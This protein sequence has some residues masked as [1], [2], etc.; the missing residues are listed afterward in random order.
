MP[1]PHS[2]VRYVEPN[3]DLEN[4]SNYS[5]YVTTDGK[6]YDKIINPED[7]CIGLS[8]TTELCN[9]GQSSTA[10]NQVVMM[11]W[12]NT[13]ENS[14]VN[15]MSGTLMP[16]VKNDSIHNN[17]NI[18]YLTT[19][20]ADM[21]VSDL[22]HYG[23]TEMIG[24][25]SVNIDFENATLPVI[26]VQ[27]TDVR[28]MSLFTPKEF[29]KNKETIN[30]KN[31]SQ[32][33]FQCFFK[34]PYPKFNITVKGFYGRPVTYE[35]TCDKFDT[36][37][38]AETGNFDVTVRFIGY[39]YSF[40]SDITTEMLLLAPYTDYLG[41]KYWEEQKQ[42]GHFTVTDV[43]G[44]KTEMPTLIETWAKIKDTLT[45]EDGGTVDTTLTREDD[46]HDEEIR[47]L[48]ELKNRYTAWYEQLE[49]EVISKY[50]KDNCF[51]R[52]LNSGEYDRIIVLIGSD[53]SSDNLST[54][55]AKFSNEMT[56]VN[57][58]LYVAIKEYNTAYGGIEPLKQI[59]KDYSSFL[60]VPL[61]NVVTKNDKDRFV[62]NGYHNDS[63][64][65]KGIADEMV[66]NR[67]GIEGEENIRLGDRHQITLRT[68]YNDGKNQKT[69]CYHINLEYTN[70]QRR[71]DR[72]T[73]DANKSYNEKKKAKDIHNRNVYLIGKLGFKPTVENFTKI[74]MAHLETLM[75]MIYTVSNE[76][77]NDS[78]RKANALGLSVGKEG[79]LSDVQ[80]EDDNLII[81]PFP[82]VTEMV[83]EDDGTQKQ[84]DTWV[85]KFDKDQLKEVDLVET[86]FNAAEYVRQ[87]VNTVNEKVAQRKQD[88]EDSKKGIERGSV[89]YPLTSFD[90]FLDS[91]VYGNDVIET[92]EKFAGSISV[93]MFDILSLNFFTNE[94]AKDNKW[95]NYA[96]KLGRTEAHNFYNSVDTTSNNNI[97]NWIKLDTGIFN[98]DY[99]L[100]TV[101]S[102][103]KE[104][105]FPWSFLESDKTAPTALMSA[106]NWLTRY[107]I[108]YKSGNSNSTSYMYQMQ[109]ISFDTMKENYNLFKT[110]E[111][112]SNHD[113]V[114]SR[115]VKMPSSMNFQALTED[116]NGHYNIIIC[117][118]Y[119]KVKNMMDVAVAE[120]VSAYSEVS[121][122]IF[123]SCSLENALEGYY[124][125]IFKN[126]GVSSFCRK[127]EEFKTK[128]KTIDVRTAI[129]SDFPLYDENSKQIKDSNNKTL[130]FTSKKEDL[131]EYFN[132]EING[133]HINSCF[134]SE[135]FN[136]DKDG[137]M[138]V[139][140]SVFNNSTLN[141]FDFLMGIDCINYETL[142]R[143][144]NKKTK[145]DKTFIYL[146]RFVVLQLGAILNQT[147]K[148][149][150]D[151]VVFENINIQEGLK[152][153]AVKYLNNISIY[154]RMVLV[155][156]YQDWEN[157]EFTTI[158]TNL[159][160][161]NGKKENF[162]TILYRM[163]GEERVNTRILLNP[164][165]PF[166]ES[167]TNQMMLP[168]LLVNGNVNHFVADN[169]GALPASLYRTENGVYKKYLDGFI[170]EL[171]QLLGVDYVVD[172]SGNMVRRS[173]EAKNTSDEMRMELYR[174]IKNIYDKWIPSSN[175]ED[176]N[177]ENF[178]RQDGSEY[179]F[180]FIDSYYNK[181][182][183]KLLLNPQR[184]LDRLEVLMAYTD[185]KSNMLSFLGYIYRDNHCMF[186][187]IQNFIDLSDR[188]AMDDMFKPLSYSTAFNPK[189]IR[190]GQDFV[191]C[192]T[193]QP[194]KY[195]DI[196]GNDYADDSFMLNDENNSPMS[197]RTR[198]A[199]GNFYPMPAFGV[200]YGKQYQSF[201]K[202]VQVSSKGATQ[203]EQGIK[204]KFSIL[205]E[206]TNKNKNGAQGQD[207]FDIYAGQ[208]FT[209]TVEMMGCAW[210]QPMMYFVLLNVPMFRGSYQI[211]KVSHSITP[212]NM[213]TKFIGCRM[214]NV[215]NKLV[216]DVF[217]D[218]EG[219]ETESI[220]SDSVTFNNAMA[221]NDNDCPY[222]VFP[223][224][225]GGGTLSGDEKQKA[226]VLMNKVAK[227][228]YDID[229]LATA[230]QKYK[231][232]AAGI[233]GNMRVETSTFDHTAVNGN[234]NNHISGGLC[235][236]RDGYGEL[237]CL[238][239]NDWQH[240][241][242]AQDDG[243]VKRIA[244][245]LGVNGVKNR[246]QEKGV[247]Y[248]IEFLSKTL[249]K[250]ENKD[251]KKNY[252]TYEGTMYSK[253]ALL[254]CSTPENAALSFELSYEKSDKSHNNDRK[255][256]ARQ[257]YDAYDN[258]QTVTDQNELTKMNEEIYEAFFS[259]VNQTAQNTESMKFEL[260][261]SYYPSK[262]AKD[263]TM[264]IGAA[265]SDN[266]PK[267]A[268]LF[269]CILNTQE[270]FRYVKTLYW[271][272]END[273]KSI[274]RVDVKLSAKDVATNQQRVWLYEKGTRGS[275]NPYGTVMHNK[276]TVNDLSDDAKKSFAKKYK[277]IGNDKF[278]VLVQVISD[279]QNLTA[280]TISDC[281]SVDGGSSVGNL[282]GF[283]GT[284]NNPLMKKVLARVNEICLAHKYNNTS[285]WY[286][287]R[288]ANG[289]NPP[290]PT[291]QCT[292][293]PSTWY[294][295]AGNQYD[296]HFYPGPKDATYR[297]TTLKNYGFKLV[298]HGTVKDA[299]ALS[300]SNFRPG[301]VS[302]Q[303]YYLKG[304][305]SAH[306]CMYTGKDWRSD[307][308]QPTIMSSRSAQ[309]R[310]GNYSV[311]IWRHPAFQEDGKTVVEVT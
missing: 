67:I 239:E 133:K 223:I 11:S 30:N 111:N 61:F 46:T 64:I 225:S 82:R 145:G 51:I 193:Y 149:I 151:E 152:N 190:N 192:Y 143:H 218:S 244:A 258:T 210:V 116:Y 115:K 199:K 89:R 25:K 188:K 184:L 265:S 217:I 91:N 191:V 250:V 255:T 208:S 305:K 222:A 233:V 170:D 166:V 70:I 171:N 101:T 252:S 311:C 42:N 139:Q 27:F 266:N 237:T 177:F 92:I 35:A 220:G 226:K 175:E 256:F 254:Q 232:A 268:K 156:Y 288:G 248:Q 33:F 180:Y 302:T 216:Q 221:N 126:D 205:E 124:K 57:N 83:T 125:D 146:P 118:D 241:G 130:L 24:I 107:R 73:S 165:S 309:G 135:V 72:L 228:I 110:S 19:N 52:T 123:K 296:L 235:Q 5:E 264:M 240:Y 12:E 206:K 137:K 253:D 31:V 121:Q 187:C 50:G 273:T 86:F 306:G 163:N 90:F 283:E 122:D 104:D 224:F 17:L 161:A 39:K 167:L 59:T 113:V 134:L 295:E 178:F 114:L 108:D 174:Y 20:Y 176:W 183:D 194:S 132:N 105:K 219:D 259:A 286:T 1:T 117:D 8:I 36:D 109:N 164:N 262:D 269:D 95:H 119:F 138:L 251:K 249:N 102:A 287:V 278:K 44:Q 65:E 301:D 181:I 246:L 162:A 185:V 186:K 213:T 18:P 45:N 214:P 78:S 263:K 154:S 14:K 94:F 60:N 15:F 243:K 260:T 99:V 267:L 43:Y 308:I 280:Q 275:D 141:P 37:F 209:C 261:H 75:H 22:V 234:D 147:L 62:F 303:Y 242:H 274:V 157:K 140:S 81:P 227:L 204:A 103:K 197:V 293:G 196:K 120:S 38:N 142:G 4:I 160:T 298:W 153:F 158:K 26:T 87:I 55:G 53:V 127:R 270:Y 112:F 285:S 155:Q 100:K 284:V 236:W 98:S 32:F 230:D 21:Y 198:G 272:Y 63:P 41:E 66:M 150:N 182:G 88:N 300:K 271:V 10:G 276:I 131:E 289:N 277:S 281:A 106:D 179:Q 79:N 54:D 69:R 172:D 6:V 159:S 77:K 279:P 80:Q 47:Q 58:D 189:N 200:T 49:K 84:Q 291:G 129:T 144:M 74:M 307:F 292:Y 9:R 201:F 16:S 56:K 310:E 2:S 229:N 297:N 282:S 169:K 212:G 23:T 294:H 173:K 97:R 40:L 7:Y 68:V 136:Y 48:E 215:A 211:Y 148:N 231:I 299:L 238:L 202:K 71:I 3:S 96:E 168:V 128:G 304:K 257:F 195:L 34:F 85:G 13:G 245:S 290:S 207:I 93:R 28:G 247:D 76:I 29:I 203:T